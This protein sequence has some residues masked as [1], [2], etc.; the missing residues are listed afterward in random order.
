MDPG[1]PLEQK[2]QSI[3]ATWEQEDEDELADDLES[4]ADAMALA[5]PKTWAL[6]DAFAK[7]GQAPMDAPSAPPPESVDM[8]PAETAEAGPAAARGESLATATAK[9]A[10]GPGL[11]D[12][13]K[14]DWKQLEGALRDAELRAMQTR[15]GERLRANA[16]EI[17]RYQP[18]LNAGRGQVEA[19]RMPLDLAKEKQGM[20]A[21]DL[22]MQ[23]QRNALGVKDAMD[24]PNSLQSQKAR[25]ALREVLGKLPAAADNWSAS[26][27]Q[28]FTSGGQLSAMVGNKRA[29]DT[30]ALKAQEDAVKAAEKKTKEGIAATETDALRREVQK[31]DPGADLTGLGAAD[32][33]A[34]RNEKSAEKRAR[35]MAA[36]AAK[37]AEDGK[38]VPTGE[39]GGIADT[40][41]AVKQVADLAKKFKELGMGTPTAKASAFFTELLGLQFTDAAE[42]N[43]ERERVQQGVGKILEGGKLAAGDETKYRR[44]LVKPGDSDEVVAIKTAG[45]MEFL[46]DLK[47]GRI[48]VLRAG[49]YRVPESLE[50]PAETPDIPETMTGKSGKKY[51]KTPQGWVPL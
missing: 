48:K 34:I 26:D 8:P 38:I 46:E 22:S 16:G 43:A 45:M 14:M 37:K 17:G 25:Q 28:R 20:E 42:F 6:S 4:G 23:S 41:V 21:R 32:L 2:L 27:I 24:D 35:I 30:A 9:P 39:L 15:A 12:P 33:R 47:A 19:A 1:D 29:A 11:R 50:T 10:G 13:S 49:G 7:G 3:I 18:D 40:D 36:A 51:R 44:M 5:D 31:L